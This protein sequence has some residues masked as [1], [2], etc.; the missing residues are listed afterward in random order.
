MARTRVWLAEGVDGRTTA[1]GIT[2]DRAGRVYIAGGPNSVQSGGPDFWVYSPRGRLLAALRVGV[3][4]PFLNDVAS[5]P[6]GAAYVTNSNAPWSFGWPG[7][8]EVG[9]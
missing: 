1:R 3:A 4:D 5:G 2:V 7:P 6:D 9:R 8:P